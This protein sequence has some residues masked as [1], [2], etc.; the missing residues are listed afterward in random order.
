VL[1]ALG[2]RKDLA[3]ASLRFG[4]GRSTRAEDIDRAVAVVG[5][6]VQHLRA[7]SPV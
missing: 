1:T 3:L 7:M 6:V 4:L 5:K 2:L